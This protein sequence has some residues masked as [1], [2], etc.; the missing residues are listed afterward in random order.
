MPGEEDIKRKLA[1]KFALAAEAVAVKR[2]RRMSADVPAERF[3]EIFKYLVEEAG[4]SFLSAITGADTGEAFEVIYHLGRQDGIVLNLKIRIPRQRPIVNTV[5]AAFPA[6][7]AY[8]REL[9]DLLGIEVAGLAPG[10]RYPLPDDWPQGD[11]PLRK[12]WKPK[13]A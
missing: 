2:P 10:R 5:T 8:E 1:E 9:M 11:H 4:F 7:E 12:D 3:A 13:N 6:A